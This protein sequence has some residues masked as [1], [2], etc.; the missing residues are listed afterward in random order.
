MIWCLNWHTCHTWERWRTCSLLEE[1]PQNQGF[2]MSRYGNPL[3]PWP[4]KRCLVWKS[5]PSAVAESV[6]TPRQCP[7]FLGQAV[8]TCWD[9]WRRLRAGREMES[10]FIAFLHPYRWC[11]PIAHFFWLAWF[12]TTEQKI[13]END[14]LTSSALVRTL[15]SFYTILHRNSWVEHL[16]TPNCDGLNPAAYIQW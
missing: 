2:I 10:D 5:I 1:I 6:G 3:L 7:A 15:H 16:G 11:F 9:A 4:Q 12:E 14:W 8:L 13:H